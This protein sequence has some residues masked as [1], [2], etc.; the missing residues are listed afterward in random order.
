MEDI[1]VS[2]DTKLTTLVFGASLNP[3]RI[4]NQVVHRLIRK[5]NIVVAIGGREG[6]INCVEVRKDNVDFQ[7][8]H[9]ITLYMNAKRQ[10]DHIDYLL[11][12]NPKRII[13]NPGAENLKF[14]LQA[15]EQG[16]EVLN[17]CTMVMLAT[18]Q[19]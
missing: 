8:V 19:Y 14:F 4:S 15:R 9:T 3:M 18:D 11:S 2:H 5:N 1:K 10:E 16:I 7:N 12:L 13:F 6:S 17:A